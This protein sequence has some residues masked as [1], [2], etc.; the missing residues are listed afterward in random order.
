MTTLR[1]QLLP[2]KAR[3]KIIAGA[4]GIHEGGIDQCT[5]DSVNRLAKR[6]KYSLDEDQMIRE[7]KAFKKRIDDFASGPFA[8]SQFRRQAAKRFIDRIDTVAPAFEGRRYYLSYYELAGTSLTARHIIA[9]VWNAIHD[10]AIIKDPQKTLEAERNFIN[11]CYESQ[12]AGNIS[13]NKTR[14]AKYDNHGTGFI[15]GLTTDSPSCMAGTLDRIVMTGSD[16]HP[17]IQIQFKNRTSLEMKLSCFICECLDEMLNSLE[18]IQKNYF[19]HQL[20]SLDEYDRLNK[21]CELFPQLKENVKLKVQ[22]EF[23]YFVADQGYQAQNILVYGV[24][25]EY[26]ENRYMAPIEDTFFLK[27]EFNDAEKELQEFLYQKTDP[28]APLIIS[29]KDFYHEIKTA[30]NRASTADLPPL[31]EALKRTKR[32]IE[33]PQDSENFRLFGKL[34]HEKLLVRYKPSIRTIVIPQKQTCKRKIAGYAL[35]FLGVALITAS[36]Y[37]SAVTFMGAMPITVAGVK[38]GLSAI[39]TGYAIATVSG[40][41]VGGIAAGI[42]ADNLLKT[43]QPKIIKEPLV[44]HPLATA[45]ANFWQ[46]INKNRASIQATT[47]NT[48]HTRKNSL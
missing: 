2:I 27:Y 24:I 45:S 36:L 3:E 16:I 48:R 44:I 28:N 17:D 23:G 18:P 1:H 4:Q 34:I 38:L 8:L 33:F 43:P 39:A 37:L 9:L 12:R 32:T 25:N 13:D 41:L 22:S 21:A 29:A 30:G 15:F 47:T 11:H 10:P 46:E 26:F 19:I 20:K 35:A 6:Y 40:S 42:A 14:E 31:I 7:V 5:K